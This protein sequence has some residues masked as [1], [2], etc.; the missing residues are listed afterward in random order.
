MPKAVLF[1]LDGTLLD[2]LSDIGGAMNAVLEKASFPT[3]PIEAY[4]QMVGKG[5]RSLVEKAAPAGKFSNSLLVS[6][7]EEYHKRSDNETTL[8]PG[9]SDLLDGLK[10]RGLVF[11]ILSNKPQV[12]TEQAVSRFLGQW[13]IPV[14]L[15]ARDDI[16]LKPSA[17]GAL[18]AASLLNVPAE[19]FLYLGDTGTDME[20]AIA[21]GMKPVGALWGF[22]DRYELV[23]AGAEVLLDRPTEL[24]NL[25]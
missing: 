21:A 2:T 9:V 4:K 23:Q 5:V 13:D 16:P 12:L 8:Y 6:M 22:R 18:E 19:D 25:V 20:T 3:H 14:V 7:R 24:L 1:D 10:S 11:G 15:G 17:V